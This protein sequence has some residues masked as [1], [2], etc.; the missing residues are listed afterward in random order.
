MNEYTLRL[1]AIAE[2]LMDHPERVMN[3]S[4]PGHVLNVVGKAIHTNVM[5]IEDLG[6]DETAEL[7]YKAAMRLLQLDQTATREEV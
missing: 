2:I 1:D 7:H 5:R 4:M 6:D 3:N